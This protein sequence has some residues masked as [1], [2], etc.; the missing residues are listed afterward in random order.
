[1]GCVP[2]ACFNAFSQWCENAQLQ[3]LTI[4]SFSQRLERLG[5]SKRRTSE[6]IVYV[7]I[8]IAAAEICFS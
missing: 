5:I 6:G 7:G 1:M 4:K 3:K 2:S 8:K